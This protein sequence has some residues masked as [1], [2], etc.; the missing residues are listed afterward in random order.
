MAGD[1][2]RNNETARRA[3]RLT[4]PIRAS[5]MTTTTKL[6]DRARGS[7]AAFAKSRAPGRQALRAARQEAI[8]KTP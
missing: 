8:R 4:R 2:K 5:A 1:D 3:G 6:E 7:E